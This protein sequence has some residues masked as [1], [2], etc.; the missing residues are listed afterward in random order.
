LSNDRYS[1]Y[2]GGVFMG[3]S[4]FLLAFQYSFDLVRG[5]R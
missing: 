1:A 4:L 2:A 3:K 5:R